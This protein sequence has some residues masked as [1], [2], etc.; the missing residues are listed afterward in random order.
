MTAASP[1][2]APA[3]P[4]RRRLSRR[5]RVLFALVPLAALLL[6]AELAIR[7]VRA[8]THFGSFRELRTDLMRRNYPAVRDPLLGYAP[9]PGYAS[10]DNHWG[11]VVSIDADGM[12]RNGD[13]PRPPGERVVA[14]VGDSFTFGDEVDDGESWPAC[15][16][17]ELQ[18]PVVN[19]GVFGYS[20]TQAVLRAETMLERFVVDAL[21]V[22]FIPD[23][24]V[25]S[26]FTRR[27]TP[28]PWFEL[29]GDGLELRGVPIDHA[30]DADRDGT[31]RRWKDLLGHSALVD[32]ILANTV[33]GWWFE[34]E[35]QVV[36]PQLAGREQ[37]LGQRLVDRV[38]VRCR[39]RSVRLLLVLQD[40]RPTPAAL[41]VLAHA[42]A[43]GI[44]VLDLASRYQELLAG[45]PSLEQRWFRGHMTPEGNAWVAREIAA[46]LRR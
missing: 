37:E 41:A 13:Q 40:R 42:R 46:A 10:T 35:K 1:P 44:D 8:P 2:P 24:L 5:R 30:A 7:L 11:T 32:A 38:A 26:T 39:E 43:R 9:Q 34:N 27:Y 6:V 33:R 29:V 15:L 21:V 20:L 18:R 14:C 22:S 16:E 28:L 25:R 45:D 36:A 3:Q 23:D 19:G 12:R 17:R 4:A 31:E